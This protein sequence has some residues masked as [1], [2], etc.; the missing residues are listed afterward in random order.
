MEIIYLFDPLCGWCYGFGSHMLSFA[1]KHTDKIKF[2]VISGGMVTGERIGPLAQIASYIK[3][4]VPRL[5]QLTGERFG[6]DF[7]KD[8]N[9]EGKTI[10]DST[11]PSKAFVILKEHFPNDQVK[12]AHAL[13]NLFYKDGRD[14]NKIESYRSLCEQLG[15]SFTD[16]EVKFNSVAYQLAT[17]EEFTEASKYGVSGY[18]TVILRHEEQYIMLA[19]GFTSTE[20][21]ENTFQSIL[22][23]E[24]LEA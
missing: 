18:P 10:M 8:L 15:M 14:F 11:P 5:E 16:F 17:Q 13:Q 6:A 24:K 20:T 19:H 1:A 4:S 21:L 23:K 12:L 7:L 22:I 3:D 9:G 2:T